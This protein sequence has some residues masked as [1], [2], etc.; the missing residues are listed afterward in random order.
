MWR[1]YLSDFC[2][3]ALA[4]DS[5]R[6]FV[7]PRKRIFSSRVLRSCRRYPPFS[8]ATEGDDVARSRRN[9]SERSG[10]GR[11]ERLGRDARAASRRASCN[12]S[13]ATTTLI[14]G[15]ASILSLSMSEVCTYAIVSYSPPFI[16]SQS[17]KVTLHF[18]QDCNNLLYPKA[19]PIRRTMVYA[20][21][22]CEYNTVVDNAL[23]YRNDL[24]TV[25]K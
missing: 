20:C 22:I 13:R 14:L 3:V 24:L 9:M 23:V 4:V 15:T 25:T 11:R 19:D 5:V 17:A 10:A 7:G 1:S 21:R 16:Y 6:S 18:C 12:L 2:A 8:M